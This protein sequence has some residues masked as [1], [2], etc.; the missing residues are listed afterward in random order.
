MRVLVVPGE[1]FQADALERARQRYQQRLG[2]RCRID[3]E[4]RESLALGGAP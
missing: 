2:T 1:G 4:L 3:F